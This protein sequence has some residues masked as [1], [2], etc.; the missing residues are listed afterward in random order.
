MKKILPILFILIIAYNDG[1]AQNTGTIRGILKDSTGQQVLR[2]A[3]VMALNS[4]DSS[5]EVSTLS[6][7]GGTFALRNVPLTTVILQISFQGYAPYFK[8]IT[9]S[10]N[11][12]SVNLDTIF[13]AVQA[14]D[15][16]NV[17][18][19]QPPIA[20]KKDTVE[21]N[22]GSYSVKPNATAE[23]LL[24]KLPGVDVDNT[25]AIKAQ[26]E[27]VQRVLVDGKRF[28]GDDPKMATKNLPPDI[29]DKIQVFD[30]LSD[31]SKFTGFDD[32]NRVKTINITTKKNTRKGY[33]GRAVGGIGTDENYDESFNMHRFDGDQQI[34]LLGQANDINKQNFTPQDILGGNTGGRRGGGPPR[35]GTAGVNATGITTT[36]AGGGN[37]KDTWG[38]NTDIT[39]SY[40]YNQLHTTN[41]QQS[42]TQNLLP[43]DSSTF[44]NQNNY[45]ISR[46][47]DHQINMNIEST[48]DTSNSIVFRPNIVFQNSSPNSSSTTLTTGGLGGKQIN[49]SVSTGSSTNTGFNINNANFIFRH[50]FA[51]KSRTFSANINVS[52]GANN[53]IGYTYAVN[54]FYVPFVKTDTINQRYI[55]SSNNFTISPTLSYTEPIGKNQIIEINYNYSYSSNNSVNKTY[56][57]DNNAHEFL[58]FD[59]LFSNSYK[60]TSHS[61]R[62]TLNYRMQKEKIRFSV[63]SG[64]QWLDQN[65]LN[66]TKSILVNTHFI[67]VTPTANFMYSF[68]R[69]QNLRIFYMGRTG[70]PSV[71]QLQPL[72]TT[73]DSI[74]FQIGNPDL[75]P[76]FTHSLRA[77]YTSFDPTTQR[78]I[79]ATI[80]AS[81]TVNDIQSSITQNP[82]GGKTTTYANLNG[83]YN[84]S[85]YFNYGFALN[86][87][88]SN[89]N[90]TTN[91]N[92]SQSQTLVN[93]V[94]NFTY[95]TTLGQTIKWTTNLKKIFDMNFS[96][97]TTY[98]IARYTLQANQN[99]NFYT[100][101]LSAEITWYSKSG[102]IVASNFDYTYNGNRAAGYNTSVP[103]WSPSVAKQVFKN[104]SGEFRLSIFDL[105]NQNTNVT[106][107][108][109]ANTI[110][111]VRSNV[112]TR[113]VMLTFTYNLRNFA[114][115]QQRMPGMF[116][117]M[118]R[119]MGPGGFGGGMRNFR[120]E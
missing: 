109:T 117:G 56:N 25:G 65:S 58:Q 18:V 99:A 42:L 12:P 8:T 116:Q 29:I 50:K 26:G 82:N 81:A 31:Q 107:N 34:S 111:D 27:T 90:F 28:F 21:F 71:T 13:M 5:V 89:L 102:W 20:V 36:W 11:R 84:L 114:G 64:V 44:N 54:N 100:E 55:D 32:G 95:N 118:F 40:F 14:K 113:Y 7:A 16:G 19:K 66:T 4:K 2:D 48:L 61:N 88:K 47:R 30:D 110:Q 62:L 38:K 23:D 92:Y 49:Q 115:Q 68:S 119:G 74:N 51:K 22:A 78:V 101:T 24:K 106:R 77:L 70:Q 46:N 37:Y 45:S 86:K 108:I 105:L 60:F 57:Y 6:G 53:G 3:S 85:G 93:N 63:G 59:S 33:F 9:L 15:L 94:S 76:Q 67:N 87:P 41:D 79:F 73:S 69:T 112:L 103:L 120:N 80:N 72:K 10:A 75:K 1:F 35:G 52:A 17:T 43:G 83:T 98:N 104:K 91:V 96:S 97:T 39:A